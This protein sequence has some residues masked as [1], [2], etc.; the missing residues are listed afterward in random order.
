MRQ[1]RMAAIAAAALCCFASL[2]FAGETPESLVQPPGT[3]TPRVVASAQGPFVLGSEPV[4]I[5][6]TSLA[7]PSPAAADDCKAEVIRCDYGTTTGWAVRLC[8]KGTCRLIPCNAPPG[9]ASTAASTVACNP[10]N[11]PC[12]NAAGVPC[13]CGNSGACLQPGF[14]FA[15]GVPF[16]TSPCPGGNCGNFQGGPFM[17]S[18][19]CDSCGTQGGGRKGRR[20][21]KH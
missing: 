11:C 9:V 5:R 21:G 17:N 16:A 12:T 15:A 6:L 3:N 14:Q 18:G 2:T 10:A 13:P 8:E 4:T 1:F 20:H 7:V 19:G